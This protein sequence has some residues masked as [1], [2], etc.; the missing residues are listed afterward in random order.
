SQEN[1]IQSIPDLIQIS[2]QITFSQ[3][4]NTIT[5]DTTFIFNSTLAYDLTI[6]LNYIDLTKNRDALQI[7]PG[8]C[9]KCFECKPCPEYL[10]ID[11]LKKERYYISSIVLVNKTSKKKRKMQEKNTYKSKP[12][13]ATKPK[14]IIQ[15]LSVAST[16]SG[17][18]ISALSKTTNIGESRKPGSSLMLLSVWE[19]SIRMTCYI[20]KEQPLQTAHT[21]LNKEVKEKLPEK[22]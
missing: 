4:Q 9:S 15:E 14:A 17:P 11:D 2:L 6:Y 20:A 16:S 19:S 5:P 12:K 3:S 1:Q 10:S 8:N 22:N 7:E 21:K 13:R 18:S